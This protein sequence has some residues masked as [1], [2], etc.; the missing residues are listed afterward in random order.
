MMFGLGSLTGTILLCTEPQWGHSGYGSSWMR[1]PL[2]IACSDAGGNA[3][4]AA[5]GLAI[6]ENPYSVLVPA[7]TTSSNTALDPISWTL[8]ERWLRCRAWQTRSRDGLGVASRMT[9]RPAQLG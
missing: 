1:T 4:S 5:R 2:P 7:S 6:G 9:I 8:S 3:I